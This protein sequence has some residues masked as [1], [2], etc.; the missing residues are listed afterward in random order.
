MTTGTFEVGETVV[1]TMINAG[2][3]PANANAP[4]ITFRVAQANHKEG[5]YDSPDRVYRQSPYN[6]QPMGETYSST[7][8]ILNVDTFSLANQVQGDFFGYVEQ[9]MTLVGKT[10]GAQATIT[11]VKLVS[12]IGSF[13]QGSF[14]IPDPNVNTNPRFEAGT[15]ILTF[16]NSSTNNQETATTLAEEGYVSSGTIETVQENIVSVR[17]ARVQNKLEFEEQAV[18]RTTGSQLVASRVIGSTTVSQRVHYWYD[19]LAQ[20]FLVDDDTGVYL[21]KCDI[22]FRTKDDADVPVTLQIRTMN[23]GLPT[24][25]IL[26]FSEVTLDP[27]QVNLSADGSVA[28]TFEFDAP[29]FLEGMGTDYAICVASNSTKYSVYISRVGENDLINDTFISNQ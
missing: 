5:P 23:N 29:V 12:D 6:G 26:P 18:A 3:G 21:T 16:V 13:L 25:K 9:N 8:V 28:T 14:F 4:R 24:Q 2:T 20:S 1:G 11:D 15:R 19:P 22:F 27:D 7:S 10:S 17:N